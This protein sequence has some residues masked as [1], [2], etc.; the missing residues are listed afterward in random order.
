MGR[1]DSGMDGQPKDMM[2]LAMSI[3]STEV[4]KKRGHTGRRRRPFGTPDILKKKK[5]REQNKKKTMQH[6]SETQPGLKLR[7]Q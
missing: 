2:P 3:A 6:G 5:K 4:Y 1:M 7:N